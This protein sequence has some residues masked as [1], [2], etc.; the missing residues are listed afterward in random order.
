MHERYV[1]L[2]L[3]DEQKPLPEMLPGQ[4]AEVRVDGSATTFL[5]RPIS[6][7]NVDT[8]Q[9]ELWLLVA[10]VGDG[11]RWMATLKPGDKLNCVLPL[12]NGFTLPHPSQGDLQS[13][14]GDLQSPHSI[15]VINSGYGELPLLLA[16]QH[17][18]ATIFA[19]EA[20]PEKLL[21]ARNS[22][23]QLVSNITFLEKTGPEQLAQ[24]QA[25]NPG[26]QL[27]TLTPH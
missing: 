4:F 18:D 24:L 19:I 16:L 2:R 11:T 5:R 6:I 12:G 1:L 17:P 13:A 14:K 9:N 20:D 8:K 10:V 25:A 21:V 7:C 22:A 15:A 27:V 23:E 26:L 3:A